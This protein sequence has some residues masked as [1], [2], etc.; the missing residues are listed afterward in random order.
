MVGQL[1]VPC[2]S[3]L[4]HPQSLQLSRPAAA[5]QLLYVTLWWLLLSVLHIWHV[6]VTAEAGR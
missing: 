3:E 6:Q 2:D 5:L 4:S 1:F